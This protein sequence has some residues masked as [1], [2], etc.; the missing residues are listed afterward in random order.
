MMMHEK[1][2]IKFVAKR[3][4]KLLFP[5]VRHL[6]INLII[7]INDIANFFNR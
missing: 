4:N 5:N 6:S 2:F 1:C 3:L 7:I